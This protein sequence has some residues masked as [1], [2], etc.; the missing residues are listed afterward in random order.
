LR[1][2]QARLD[3]FDDAP[4]PACEPGG[5]AARHFLGLIC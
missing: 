4:E 2:W 1:Q 3:E 5:S